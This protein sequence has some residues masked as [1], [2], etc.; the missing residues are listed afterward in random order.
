MI[1]LKR[2][3][4]QAAAL[5]VAREDHPLPAVE[6]AALRIHLAICDA[7]PRFERQLLTLRNSLRQWRNYT[8]TD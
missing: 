3:C 8:T 5:L 7:C 2:T 4:K 6:R 1:P